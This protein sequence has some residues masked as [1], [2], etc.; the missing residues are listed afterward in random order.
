VVV[1]LGG[2]DSCARSAKPRR[3]I[4]ARLCVK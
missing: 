3:L 4:Y 1:C 2:N